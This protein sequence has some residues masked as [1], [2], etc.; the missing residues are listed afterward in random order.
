MK[1][2]ASERARKTFPLADENFVHI[3]LWPANGREEIKA[4]QF[5]IHINRLWKF[6]FCLV[7]NTKMTRVAR[8]SCTIQVIVSNQS[9][10]A[11]VVAIAKK[12]CKMIAHQRSRDHPFTYQSTIS[13]GSLF[14][15]L[16]PRSSLAINFPIVQNRKTF[17]MEIRTNFL[18]SLGRLH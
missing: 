12:W 6:Y 3:A 14:T 11:V 1:R 9:Q 17:L 13:L 5:R 4:N 16:F 15:P 10:P 18:A 2:N 8:E 7:A